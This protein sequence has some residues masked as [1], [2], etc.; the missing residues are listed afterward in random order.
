MKP[1]TAR[2][3]AP[4][5]VIQWIADKREL[6]EIAEIREAVRSRYRIQ[7]VRAH[8]K[9]QVYEAFTPWLKTSCARI[10]YIGAHGSRTGLVDRRKDGLETMRWEQLGEHLAA[11][12]SAFQHPVVLVL[13]ACYSSLAP[14]IWTKLKLRIPVSHVICVA[15]EPLVKDV[16]QMIV[17]ILVNDRDEESLLAGPNQEIT[18]W[19]ESISALRGSLPSR[20]KLRV[21]VKGDRSNGN[22]YAFVEL[23]DLG[24]QGSIQEEL[25]KRTNQRKVSSLRSA[26]QEGLAEP[27]PSNEELEGRKARAKELNRIALDDTNSL[28]PSRPLPG[29]NVREQRTRDRATVGTKHQRPQSPLDHR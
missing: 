3:H 20:L 8:F 2:P 26:V 15:E 19:D 9:E 25:E 11:V 22:K 29:R 7:T 24:E 1:P 12:P 21:F 4:V 28:Q 27:V 23:G 16:V 14:R 6:D 5:L 18:Y 13:G 10:L 17:Q